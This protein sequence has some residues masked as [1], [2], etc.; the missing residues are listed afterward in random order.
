MSVANYGHCGAWTET[1]GIIAPLQE[2]MLQSWDG[3][4]R[5]FPA[6]PTNLSASFHHFR[7]EGAFLVSASW[8]DATVVSA[9]IFSEVGGLCRLYPP[10]SEGVQ[11]T[12]DNMGQAVRVV[13]ELARVVHFETQTGHTYKLSRPA[14]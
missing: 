7:A 6:W 4:L 2:M 13:T 8:G 11:V 9:E 12:D 5:L 1:L 14:K 3:I 10:W